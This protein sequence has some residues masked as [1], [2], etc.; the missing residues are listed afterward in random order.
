MYFQEGIRLSKEKLS[1]FGFLPS[2]SPALWGHV[3]ISEIR[4][5]LSEISE[6][7]DRLHSKRLDCANFKHYLI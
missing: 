5:I 7:K 6:E 1:L 4:S 3:L 2:S